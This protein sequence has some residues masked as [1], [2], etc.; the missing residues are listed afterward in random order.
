MQIIRQQFNKV[1]R[2][3]FTTLCRYIDIWGGR[4]RGGSH[5]ATDYF[6][7]LIVQPGYFRGV[8]MRSIFSD[9]RGSLWQD[10]KDRVQTAIDNGSINEDDIEL[11]EST[12][13]ATYSPTGNTIISKGFKRSSGTQS[14]KLKSLAGIT[15]VIIEECEEVDADDFMKL[16]DS[17]RLKNVQIQIFRLF[18]PPS[19]NHWLI[20]RY[21]NLIESEAVDSLGNHFGVQNKDESW[22]SGWYRAIQKNIPGLL[23]IHS[24]YLDNIQN[25]NTSTISNYKSYGDKSSPLYNEDFY[26]RDV[27]GLISEGKR[28]RILTKCRPITYKEFEALPY[29]KFYGID[30]GYSNDPV[31]DVEIKFHNNKAYINECI[32]QVGLTD[33]DLAD[34]MKAMGIGRGALHYADSSEPKS[35][36]TLRRKGFAIIPSVKGADSVNNGIKYLQSLE[37]FITDTSTNV[38]MEV[39]EYSWHLNSNK[40]PTDTPIDNYNHAIDAIRYALTGHTQRGSTKINAI[41]TAR[42]TRDEMFSDFGKKKGGQGIQVS[43]AKV[44]DRDWDEDDDD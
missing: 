24:T 17:L 1:F 27:C 42:S 11:S 26:C 31:A 40:E 2:A 5:F 28:G 8:F 16:D 4:A 15:H 35:I 22:S 6:L 36:E 14:A 29:K 21:Y 34:K 3:V 38:W 10:F 7:Y 19:K 9:I 39:E 25:V 30:F 32:Y 37:L 20:K 23:S 33:D 41:S 43:A 12:M 13:T 44:R 18:N